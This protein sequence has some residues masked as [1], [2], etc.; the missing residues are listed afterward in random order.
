MKQWPLPREQVTAIDK[1]FADRLADGHVREPTSPH[2][3]PTFCVR[4]ATGGWWIVHVFN[5][6]NDATVPAQTPIPR[7]DVVIDGVSKSTIFS[8]MY[9]TDRFYQI[10][11]RGRDMPYKAVSTPSGMI[12]GWLVMPQGLS[13]APA[14]VNRCDTN[15]LRLVR[16]F[17]PSYFDD[18][19]V[20]SRA[21]DG[22]TDVEIHNFHFQKV[23][24]LRR[25][26][27]FVREPQE[28]FIRSERNTTSWLHRG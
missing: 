20:H 8:S 18:V 4:K 3:S 7:K 16:D 19:F 6:L 5:K 10:R 14:T 13:K 17:A 21:M 28:V 15:L 22:K 24:T 11:M 9:L 23:L 1:F 2:S 26:R 12:W 27:K 25:E